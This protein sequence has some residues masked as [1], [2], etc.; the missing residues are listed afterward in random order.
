MIYALVSL[1]TASGYR[2]EKEI[3]DALEKLL[4]KY[5]LSR[6]EIFIT[7]KLVPRNN[8]TKQQ[9]I[10][11]V[12]QSLNDLQ[13]NYIDLY[14][15]HWPGVI[16][17]PVESSE[18]STYRWNTFEALASCQKQGLCRSVGV[19]NY[20]VNH[21]KELLKKCSDDIRP[22]VNQVEW[23]PHYH[24]RELQD[25]CRKE[26]IFLQAYSSL[27]SS[28][29]TALR[30]DPI[31]QAIASK[32]QK[33][34]SQVLLQWA[35]QQNIGILPKARSSTHIEENFDLNF[36]IPENDMDQLSNLKVIQKYA[37]NPNTVV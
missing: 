24:Q 29:T 12:K 15:I 10:D 7:S 31:V 13:T 1:D 16:G 14:L 22:T 17:I 33:T 9:V 2:N 25:F 27:G 3:G 34:P 32:L 11:I 5:K 19:S 35:F 8:Q 30:D 23:H 26:N 20:T 18:N 21:L 37:W 28:N 4:P 6:E 36:V